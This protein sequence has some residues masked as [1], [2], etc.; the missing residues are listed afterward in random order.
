MPIQDYSQKR[1]KEE[2]AGRGF[3]VIRKTDGE[4]VQGEKKKGIGLGLR[5]SRLALSGGGKQYGVRSG[6]IGP[7]VALPPH[8]SLALLSLFLLY[9]CLHVASSEHTKGRSAFERE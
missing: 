1:R 8:S 6:K 3:K 2:E 4:L 5:C 9:V 7:S